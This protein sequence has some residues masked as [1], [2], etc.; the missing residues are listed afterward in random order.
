MI[1]KEELI[2]L[3]ETMRC[4]QLEDDDSIKE[5]LS[6]VADKSAITSAFRAA[7]NPVSED[8]TTDVNVIEGYF[9]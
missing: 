2:T 7:N 8:I 6:S 4:I 3:I 5:V 1:R 9:K